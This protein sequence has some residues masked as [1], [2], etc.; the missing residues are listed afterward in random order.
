VIAV[1]YNTDAPTSHQKIE[2]FGESMK[3][4]S[5]STCYRFARIR[6]HLRDRKE[7]YKFLQQREIYGI[8]LKGD[9]A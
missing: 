7:I 8:A 6:N 4:M 2:C 3:V 1:I 5:G 9:M